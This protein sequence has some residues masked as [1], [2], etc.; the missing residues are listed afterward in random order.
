MKEI[1]LK[2]KLIDLEYQSESIAARIRD[3]EWLIE[4]DEERTDS[5][6]DDRRKA[7]DK[8]KYISREIAETKIALLEVK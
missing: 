8:L 4:N 2:R 3:I 7:I 5:S 6:L 1:E